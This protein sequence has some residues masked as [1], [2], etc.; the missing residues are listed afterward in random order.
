MRRI[1]AVLALYILPGMSAAAAA[2]SVSVYSNVCINQDSG[3]LNGIRIVILRLGDSPYIAIQQPAGIS[4]AETGLKKLSPDDFGKGKISFPFEYQKKPAPF[5][6]TI[7]EKEIV[8]TFDNKSFMKDYG[9]KIIQLRRVPPSQ[10]T[11]G[12]CR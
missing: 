8:G 10:K 5:T 6:G 7:T 12:V 11:Y 2:E 1:I 4:F 3:D 9:W